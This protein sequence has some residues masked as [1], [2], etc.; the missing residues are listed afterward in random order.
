M[1][2]VVRVMA[3]FDDYGDFSASRIVRHEA[4]KEAAILVLE[5]CADKSFGDVYAGVYGR[6]P[7]FGDLQDEL[8]ETISTMVVTA[9]VIAAFLP[10]DHALQQLRVCCNYFSDDQLRHIMN[11]ARMK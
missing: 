4:L 3:V 9:Y 6:F 2:V 11:V 7:E 8:A 10:G 5:K 1:V